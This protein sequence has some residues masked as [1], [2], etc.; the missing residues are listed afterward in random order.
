MATVASSVIHPEHNVQFQPYTKFI[1]PGFSAE[2]FKDLQH[3]DSSSV[4]MA[5]Q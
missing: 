2:A 5:M 4:G 1:M 3:T